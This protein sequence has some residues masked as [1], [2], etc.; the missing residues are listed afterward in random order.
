MPGLSAKS[1]KVALIVKLICLKAN[2]LAVSNAELL[3]TATA[4]VKSLI[5]KLGTK[6]TVSKSLRRG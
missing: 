3:I 5:G 1:V 2:N 4:I 6:R